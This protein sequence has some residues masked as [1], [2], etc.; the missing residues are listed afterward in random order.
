VKK[1]NGVL[2][3]VVSPPPGILTPEQQLLP[4]QSKSKEML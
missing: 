1:Q 4:S 3:V 2:G